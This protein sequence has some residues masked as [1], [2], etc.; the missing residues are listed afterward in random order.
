MVRNPK[1]VYARM[2]G[3][4]GS[5]PLAKTAGHDINYISLTGA[6]HAI[7]PA[8]K[9]TPPLNL[10]G[11]YG[12]GALYLAFGVMAAIYETQRSGEGQVV[13]APP[14]VTTAN[15]GGLEADAPGR[16]YKKRST[17]IGDGSGRRAAFVVAK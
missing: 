15:K 5:G 17:A 4:G 11:D 13:D 3:F 8:E 10:I 9:P 6:L 1:L 12:G 2:T 7:G 16:G 14:L